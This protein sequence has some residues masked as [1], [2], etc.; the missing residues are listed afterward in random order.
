MTG[1]S[2][3]NGSLGVVEGAAAIGAFIG[4]EGRPVSARRVLYLSEQ[5]RIRTFHIGRRLCATIEDLREDLARLRAGGE[6]G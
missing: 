4:A 1:K 3:G 6:S 5:R 2:S